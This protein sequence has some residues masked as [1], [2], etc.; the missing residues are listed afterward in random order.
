[1]DGPPVS[2]QA[3]RRERVTEWRQEVRR[4]AELYWS[5]QELPVAGPVR[6]EITHFYNDARLDIDNIPKP[7][8]DAL[9][10]L[11]FLDDDQVTDLMCRKR[12]LRSPLRIANP[13]SVLAEALGRDNDFLYIVVMEAPNQEVIV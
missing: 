3:R 9:K 1:V 6:L 7:I 11:I 2:Q 8:I 13:S 5:T 10:G 12:D 4:A